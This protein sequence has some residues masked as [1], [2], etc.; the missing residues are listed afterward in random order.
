[1][2][3]WGCKEFKLARGFNETETTEGVQKMVRKEESVS[4]LEYIRKS[5]RRAREM[6]RK[7]NTWAIFR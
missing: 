1:M 5:E 2:S 4:R 3:F 6:S 7:P